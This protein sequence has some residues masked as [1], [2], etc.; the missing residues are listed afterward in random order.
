M[1]SFLFSC[2]GAF[3]TARRACQSNLPSTASFTIDSAPST[4]VSGATTAS[5]APSA[6][7]FAP[8][9]SRPVV[10]HSRALSAPMR[11]GKRTVPPKPGIRPSL[12]SGKP[13]EAVVSAIRMSHANAIS[14]PPPNAKPLTAAMV[15][16]GKSSK[17]SNTCEVLATHCSTSS[18]SMAKRPVNSVISA[19]TI[20]ADFALRTTKPFTSP[21][22][23]R[24]CVASSSSVTVWRSNL[25]TEPSASNTSSAK[26]SSN[27]LTERLL[28]VYII[29]ISFGIGQ[30]VSELIQQV[31][32]VVINY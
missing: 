21:L 20:N 28:P 23:S 11:R 6:R 30:D 17:R 22:A 24:A 13:M 12:T 9:L 1:A 18:S 14:Q 4:N 19:P 7:A 10:I 16:N 15:G 31:R 2:S 26:P 25:F 29:I 5:T 32:R 8:F 3:L 27:R